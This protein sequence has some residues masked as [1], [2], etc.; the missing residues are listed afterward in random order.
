MLQGIGWLLIIS[1]PQSTTAFQLGRL[2]KEASRLQRNSV[3]PQRPQHEMA[4]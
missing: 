2:L 4:V 3:K 1:S